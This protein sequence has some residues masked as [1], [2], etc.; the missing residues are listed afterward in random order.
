MK[1]AKN[2]FECL[3]IETEVSGIASNHKKSM[4]LPILIIPRRNWGIYK[5]P[6]ELN[7]D[8]TVTTSNLRKVRSVIESARNLSPEIN[9]CIL[10]EGR[11]AFIVEQDEFTTT[12]QFR[13]LTTVVH[14]KDDAGNDVAETSCVVNSRKFAAILSQHN[15]QHAYTSFSIKRDR[16]FKIEFEVKRNV[17]LTCLLPC[18][19]RDDE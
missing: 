17:V 15:F 8:I 7:Y 6:T 10:G 4:Q 5:L 3:M 12:C 18:V 9:I 14:K 11:L 16:V 13:Q 2:P 19:Y 1:L